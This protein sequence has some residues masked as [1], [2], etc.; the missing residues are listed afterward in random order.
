MSGLTKVFK[1]LALSSLLAGPVFAQDM[2]G[3]DST[4]A[5]PYAGIAIGRASNDWSWTEGAGLG[6]A[7]AD[8]KGRT[9]DLFAGY[10]TLRDNMLLGL[11]FSIGNSG[12]DSSLTGIP[13]PGPLDVAVSR[14]MALK[15]RVGADLGRYLP[16]AFVGAARSKLESNATIVD[17]QRNGWHSGLS[18]GLGVDVQV[19]Q[20]GF[21]RL[22]LSRANLGKQNYTFCGPPCSAQ[23]GIRTTTLSVGFGFNF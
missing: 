17:A 20:K 11:E 15:G 16:Y 14:Q 2:S 13:G 23:Q 19:T 3:G 5:G 10:N 1:A 9:V 22:E 12:A 6:S 4:W 8:V 7:S 21:A 18:F